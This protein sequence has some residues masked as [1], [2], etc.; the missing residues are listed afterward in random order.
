MRTKWDV[1]MDVLEESYEGKLTSDQ[2]KAMEYLANSIVIALD[3]WE[4]TWSRAF[5]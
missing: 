4:A 5:Q 3:K 1:V 2:R